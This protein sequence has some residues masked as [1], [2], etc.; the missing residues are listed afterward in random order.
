M[1]LSKHTLQETLFRMIPTEN[2][3][4][5]ESNGVISI[6]PLREESGLL[7][8]GVGSKLTAEKF[9]DYTREEKELECRTFGK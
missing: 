7:G 4:L 2:V 3:R 1:V 6:T 8:I 9:A 5:R